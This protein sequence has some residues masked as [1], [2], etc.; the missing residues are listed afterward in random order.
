[1]E[2][3]YLGRSSVWWVIEELKKEDLKIEELKKGELEKGCL[4]SMGLMEELME[5]C[6]GGVYG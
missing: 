5:E 4:E 1:M 6:M 2:E 3:I